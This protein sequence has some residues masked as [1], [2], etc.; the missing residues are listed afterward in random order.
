MGT[1]CVYPPYLVLIALPAGQ[2]ISAPT[3]YKGLCQLHHFL[4]RRQ[5]VLDNIH[6]LHPCIACRP[7]LYHDSQG[8]HIPQELCSSM[9]CND[10]DGASAAYS[11]SSGPLWWPHAALWRYLMFALEWMK[12]WFPLEFLCR[13]VSHTFTVN[14]DH[15]G[16]TRFSSAWVLFMKRTYFAMHVLYLCLL[17]VQVTH[18]N[19]ERTLFCFYRG[20]WGRNLLGLCCFDV[21]CVLMSWCWGLVEE[22]SDWAA[23]I[24]GGLFFM[25]QKRRLWV[26][27]LALDLNAPCGRASLISCRK[28]SRRKTR[29]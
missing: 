22:F 18:G 29:R 20:K 7:R 6:K 8:H 5:L 13:E 11:W 1:D 10:C 2:A 21:L 3:I 24:Q 12:V 17:H 19:P 26:S 9:W 25:E 27:S 16:T 4:Y 28:W 15:V 14:T 23:W